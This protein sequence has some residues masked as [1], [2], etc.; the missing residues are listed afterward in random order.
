[1]P[2]VFASKKWR[3]AQMQSLRKIF[4]ERS[5]ID[6][7]RA[8]S[9]PCAEFLAAV[10]AEVS[11]AVSIQ[12]ATIA[13]TEN[14]RGKTSSEADCARALTSDQISATQFAQQPLPKQ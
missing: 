11:E 3:P 8:W 9:I 1:M 13:T 10:S 2:P 5:K 6:R 7:C 4:R 14:N 12:S